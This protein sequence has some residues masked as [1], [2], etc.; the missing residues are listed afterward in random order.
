MDIPS[1]RLYHVFFCLIASVTAQEGI[2]VRFENHG[3]EAVRLYWTNQAGA[4]HGREIL[5]SGQGC[6]QNTSVGHTYHLVATGKELGGLYREV[7]ILRAGTISFAANMHGIE[8]R[9]D[10][11]KESDSADHDPKNALST[12]QLEMWKPVTVH[13]INSASKEMF[14]SWINPMTGETKLVGTA[15]PGEGVSH[16]TETSH[17]FDVSFG[18]A[19]GSAQRLIVRAGGDVIIAE[20]GEATGEPLQATS[21]ARYKGAEWDR[22]VS[23]QRKNCT[24][25]FKGF[26]DDLAYFCSSRHD[27]RRLNK[28]KL[29]IS[30]DE[31]A[32]MRVAKKQENSID[33]RDQPKT[34]QNF[35]KLGFKVT[36]IPAELHEKLLAFWEGK[37]YEAVPEQS[38]HYAAAVLP[39]R[40]SDSWVLNLPDELRR[41]SFRW[42]RG[43]ISDWTGVPAQ[44]LEET[45]LYG[46][47]MYHRDTVLDV[48]VDI[49]TTHALSA[50]MEIDRNDP[51]DNEPWPLEVTDHSG[52][53]HYVPGRKG[54]LILY[55][56]ATCPHGRQSPFPGRQ[57]V[58]AFVHFRPKGWPDKYLASAAKATPL[59]LKVK[60]K[61]KQDL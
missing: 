20:S 38:H 43:I 28:G 16:Y 35:T 1:W 61:V 45:A 24:A 41:E 11:V 26:P 49:R 12:M 30:D 39:D 29:D 54:Q 21:L 9:G 51:E 42:V 57:M 44:D 37:K 32:E 19:S 5:G 4:R 60:L 25:T 6:D 17:V 46:I 14:L 36:K 15:K 47:R 13:F 58:N 50:I 3:Q 59:S 55:E 53:V 8:L 22:I 48:H 52:K 10:G 7:S 31:Y 27:Y 56:S 34:F 18:E 23:E 33:V 40:A 2:K